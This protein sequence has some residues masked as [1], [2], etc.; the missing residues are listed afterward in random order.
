MTMQAA[1]PQSLPRHPYLHVGLRS[2][3]DLCMA[4][5]VIAVGFSGLTRN[6]WLRDLVEPWINVHWLFGILLF[7]WLASHIVVTLKHSR[8]MQAHD[9][10]TMSR[11]LSRT[12]YLV[13]YAVIG[14]KLSFSL[15]TAAWTGVP[16][17]LI[18]PK[19]DYQMCLA[20]GLVALCL[21]RLILSRLRAR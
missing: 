5:I 2:I 18:D 7:A 9:I 1:L 19:N 20:S 11:Q 10:H 12:A 17:T 3:P 14:L 6:F 21:V 4:S 13:L 15:I 16:A 8:H